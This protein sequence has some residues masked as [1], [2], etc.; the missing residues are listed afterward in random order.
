MRAH[1]LNRPLV[2]AHRSLLRQ[3][4][5]RLRLGVWLG[6]AAALF[7]VV[8][9][10]ADAVIVLERRARPAATPGDTAGTERR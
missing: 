3:P 4:P 1:L 9:A 10:V 2:D 5:R 8:P 7:F 6:G